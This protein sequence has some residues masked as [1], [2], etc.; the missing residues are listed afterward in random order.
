MDEV[1]TF[2]MEIDRGWERKRSHLAWCVV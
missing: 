1:S 2:L